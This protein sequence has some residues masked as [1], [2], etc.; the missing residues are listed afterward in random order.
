MKDEKENPVLKPT[1]GMLAQ[2]GF[3]V[4]QQTIKV[5]C[6]DEKT[7]SHSDVQMMIS[8]PENS[9]QLR[10]LSEQNAIKIFGIVSDP[11]KREKE[12]NTKFWKEC[13]GIDIPWEKLNIS[14]TNSEF[15]FV[16]FIPESITA[17]K[18]FDIYEKRFGKDKVYNYYAEKGIDKNIKIQQE[19]PKGDYVICHLGGEEPDAK[20][21]N[22]SYDI[23][24]TDGNKYMIPKEGIIAA[25]RYRFE[26]GKMYDEK[27]ATFFHALNADGR[28]MHMSRDNDGEF[29]I[30]WN[31]TDR[32]DAKFGPRQVSF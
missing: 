27:G 14:N 17:Q 19:R 13:F 12:K 8:D 10:E 28:V 22:K 7:L 2:L 9:K 18:V 21:L 16:E 29:R 26:T 6:E 23:F 32:Q 15:K 20:H 31:D 24:S 4:G 30:D 1:A 3:I 25:L 11:W 5:L